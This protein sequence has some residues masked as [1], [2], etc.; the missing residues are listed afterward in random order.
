[1]E[2]Q[3]AYLRLTSELQA[4]QQKLA[5]LEEDQQVNMLSAKLLGRT[6]FMGNIFDEI[7]TDIQVRTNDMLSYYPNAGHLTV[8]IN[9]NKLVKSKGTTKKEI[10]VNISNNG[11][12]TSID[13]VSGGQQ[14][15][16]ELCSDLAI[17]EA[18]KARSGKA[19]QWVCLDEVMDGL[20]LSE[21]EAVIE[22]IK[23]RVKGLVLII[24]HSSE[25]KESFDNVITVEYDR[26]ESNVVTR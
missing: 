12:L 4:K 13:D 16:I 21:K 26:K 24:E 9:S 23:Q 2:K 10:S 8:E 15:G 22:M 11:I 7:L 19:L 20:G 1:M 17:A 14:A 25:I 5:E 18:I 3:S 6:G